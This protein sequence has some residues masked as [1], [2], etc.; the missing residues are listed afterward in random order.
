MGEQHCWS[1]LNFVLFEGLWT[2]FSSYGEILDVF[3]LSEER[4]SGHQVIPQLKR[5][6]IRLRVEDKDQ[7]FAE[8]VEE[9]AGK[10][11]I[12]LELGHLSHVDV[13]IVDY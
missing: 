4:N 13:Q 6:G 8:V 5:G 9:S 12:G 1:I 3:E 11:L 7:Q 2:F 10:H